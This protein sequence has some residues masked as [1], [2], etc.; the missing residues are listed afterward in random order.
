M[1]AITMN[2]HQKRIQMKYKPSREKKRT[3]LLWLDWTKDE[4]QEYINGMTY[5]VTLYAVSGSDIATETFIINT[6]V[7]PTPGIV[8]VG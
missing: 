4:A 6:Y 3:C 1:S 5:A 7:P 2:K 8:E